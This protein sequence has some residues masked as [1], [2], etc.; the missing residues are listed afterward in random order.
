MYEHVLGSSAGRA[1]GD[2]GGG[3]AAQAGFAATIA[4]DDLA[5]TS[6]AIQSTA[7]ASGSSRD[8]REQRPP[9]QRLAPRLRGDQVEPGVAEERR[10]GD[11]RERSSRTQSASSIATKVA[12]EGCGL[13][14]VEAGPGDLPV[15]GDMLGR[16]SRAQVGR[17]RKERDRDRAEDEQEPEARPPEPSENV[18]SRWAASERL[19]HRAIVQERRASEAS[20]C[21]PPWRRCSSGC[22][23]RQP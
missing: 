8:E 4:S 2:V 15:V 12:I 7:R 16:Q 17:P 21:T 11:R 5:T 20:V 14:Q 19:L 10:A 6:N 1:R 13:E 9:S 22:R 18:R 3:P 23:M